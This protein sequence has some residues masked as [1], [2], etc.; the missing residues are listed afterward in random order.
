MNTSD[1]QSKADDSENFFLYQP[2]VAIL[3]I[4]TLVFASVL[5][6][7]SEI[8]EQFNFPSLSLWQDNSEASLLA[9]PSGEQ[10][11]KDKLESPSFMTSE[12]VNLGQLLLEM[13]NRKSSSSSTTYNQPMGQ[14]A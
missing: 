10:L 8:S 4:S 1:N 7:P 5:F 14:G 12:Q 6:Y 11:T 2:L 9:K 3:L 13:A